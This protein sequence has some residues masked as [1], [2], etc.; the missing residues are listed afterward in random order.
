[1][2]KIKTLSLKQ[3]ILGCLSLIY[4]IVSC[5]S[6]WLDSYLIGD[7]NLWIPAIFAV[8][9]SVI[10]CTNV[11][12]DDLGLRSLLAYPSFT[13]VFWGLNASIVNIFIPWVYTSIVGEP[14]I[15]R[16]EVAFKQGSCSRG[17]CDYYLAIATRRENYQGDWLSLKYKFF[18]N[19]GINKRGLSVSKS[20]YQQV[21]CE[22]RLIIKGLKSDIGWNIRSYEIDRRK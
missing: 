8:P 5:G 7:D 19:H 20:F 2:S 9:L 16:A 4:F 13:F 15:L 12:F 22:D 14:F 18:D 1:M 11:K 10:L 21:K 3:K 6:Y 17:S